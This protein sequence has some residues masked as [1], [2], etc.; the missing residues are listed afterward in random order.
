M[1]HLILT[2]SDSGAGNLK[3]SG[4]ADI[5]IPL[6]FE[7]AWGPVPSDAELAASVM[8]RSQPH[9]PPTDHGWRGLYRRRFG[10]PDR[11]EIGLMDFCERCETIE[12]WID[13]HP[14]AQLQLIWL[15]DYLR[16]HEKIVAKLALLQAD[17]S[18]G[19]HAPEELV[20]WRL[21][22][23]KISNLHLEMASAAWQAYRAPTPQHWFDLRSKDLSVLPQ[24]GQSVLELLEELPG[25]ATGLGAT[26]M[27]ML[28]LISTGNKGP[29]D[30][31]PGYRKRNKRRVFGF[32][33]IGSL[34]DG[35]V[36]CPAPAVS[37]IADG[38][39][40]ELMKD[41]GRRERYRQS[42][43]SLTA[44]GKAIL[45]Q[46]EDF[47]RHNP[48]H[49]WWGGTELSNDRLWRWDPRRRVLM[50]P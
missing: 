16:P 18:I 15:L 33:E 24:L 38:S 43:L 9:D 49:R 5:V 23:V 44:L 21:P 10:E 11:N 30:L 14:N 36:H 45:A 37:G 3:P 48:V 27:R 32:Y 6:F 7:F 8:Q 42:R 50:A 47:S 34:L 13:P 12:L 41:R 25:P 17:V 22:A 2:T 19:E 29:F 40:S 39:F 26:E 1:T 35:L 4:L 20:Q 31:F 46:T 28:G